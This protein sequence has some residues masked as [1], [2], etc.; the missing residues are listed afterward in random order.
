MPFGLSNA[1]ATFQA[2]MDELFRPYMRKII[3][4]FFD[5]ILVY[6]KTLEDHVRHLEI[7][8]QIFETHQLFANRKK[9]PFGQS[10][11]DYLGHFIS[12]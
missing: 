10:Q 8:L 5:D 7:I 4:L 3:L 9:C 6:S 12:S 11:V 1:P 2:L